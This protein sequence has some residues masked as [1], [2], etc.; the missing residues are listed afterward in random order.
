MLNINISM[1]HRLFGGE[2]SERGDTTLNT[3]HVGKHHIVVLQ[4]YNYVFLRCWEQLGTNCQH[5]LVTGLDT[6]QLTAWEC[7]PVYAALVFLQST[8]EL[9]SKSYEP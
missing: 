6:Y 9:P 1:G 3:Q 5:C 7:V 2:E 8:N 4:K